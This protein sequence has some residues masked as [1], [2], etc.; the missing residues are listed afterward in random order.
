MLSTVWELGQLVWED[1]T[2]SCG[3]GGNELGE[4][5]NELGGVN[6][7]ELGGNVPTSWKGA[8][9]SCPPHGQVFPRLYS[10]DKISRSRRRAPRF[11]PKSRTATWEVLIRSRYQCDKYCVGVISAK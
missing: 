2:S 10:R 6:G 9:T 8:A 11:T 7:N 4:N 3:G 1:A 5:G